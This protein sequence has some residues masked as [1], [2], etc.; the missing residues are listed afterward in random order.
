MMNYARQ[1]L[2]RASA[3]QRLV[4]RF[5]PAE[6]RALDASARAKWVGMIREHTH[7]YR[8]ANAL[9]AQ[10]IR[11]YFGAASAVASQSESAHET[12]ARRAAVRLLELSYAHDETVRA[13]LTISA[14]Q[15]TATAIK[16][17]PFMRSLAA[18]EKLAAAILAAYE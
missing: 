1:A 8:R 11:M 15:R 7:A 16:S 18:S 4:E 12:D 13:A 6:T 14:E 17:S 2:L 10:D 5:S 3:L 9:L